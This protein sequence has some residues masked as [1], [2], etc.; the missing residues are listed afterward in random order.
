MRFGRGLA[1]GLVAL[2][3]AA[4]GLAL[5][6]DSTLTLV[7]GGEGFDGPPKFSVSFAGTPVG[8]GTIEAAIDTRKDGRFA[9][10]AA[11]DKY[12]KTFTFTIPEAVFKPDAEIAVRLTNEAHGAAGSGDD[13]ELYLKSVAVN[14]TAVPAGDLTMRSTLGIEPTAMLAGYLVVS[15]GAVEAVA[16]APGAGWGAA[17]AASAAATT[18]ASPKPAEATAAATPP[19]DSGAG[20]AAMPSAA[21]PATAA[22]EAPVPAPAKTAEAAPAARQAVVPA[23]KPATVANAAAAAAPRHPSDVA[24]AQPAAAV[25]MASDADEANP[26]P[27]TG[28]PTCG[29]TQ[30]F[31][32]TGFNENS[33][34]LTPNIAG[35][36]DAVIKAIGTQK[37]AVRITGYSSTEGDYA[38]NALFSIE[39]AQNTLRYLSDR[40]VKFRRY[41]ANGVGETRQFGPAPSA[42]R[43]VVVRVSP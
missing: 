42:N 20:A 37:C 40:G 10:A 30:A 8:N 19:A 29:L 17:D 32:I 27:E 43:R 26:E 18:Q 25:A 5:G 3:A 31:Q 39:R 12:V 2:V 14:G 23:E 35:Q 6:A 13:R 11:K 21:A 28:S 33:N 34:E 4:P 24:E 7:A 16:K 9:D 36:L 1:T 15:E 22:P 38:H 41:S